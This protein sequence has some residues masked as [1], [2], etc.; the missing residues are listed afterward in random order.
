MMGRGYRLQASGFSGALLAALLFLPLVAGAQGRSGG[1]AEARQ[2]VQEANALLVK[3]KYRQAEALYKEAMRKDVQLEDA[4]NRYSMLLYV[5]RRHEEGIK[6]ARAG[7]REVPY[8]TELRALLGM[9]LSRLGRH[10]EAHGH[11]R[12]AAGSHQDRFEIQ[13]VYAQTCLRQKDYAGAIKG[14]R[15]YFKHRPKKISR[16]DSAFSVMLATALLRS[17]DLAGA[18]TTVTGVL[19]AHPHNTGAQVVMAE[20]LLRA[21]DFSAAVTA[22]E[23]LRRKTR[24][25]EVR[26]RLGQAYVGIR[27]FGPA[28]AL[29]DELLT[30]R[31]DDPDA[32]L[33][34]GDA[35]MGL[36]RHPTALV[37]Y[38]KAAGKAAGKERAAEVRLRR[39][40]ALLA[41]GRHSDVL[42][43]LPATDLR[44]D[45]VLTVRLRAA[46]G[47]GQ[48]QLA[49]EH[50]RRL[51]KQGAPSDMEHP[52][53]AGLALGAAGKH[54]EAIKL[55]A[56]T[57]DSSPRHHRAR[58]A[59]VRSLCRLAAEEVERGDTQKALALLSRARKRWP[60]SVVVNRNLGLLNLKLG[61]HEASLEA[62]DRV[63][64]RAP[65]DYV[66]SRLAGRALAAM[67]QFPLALARME[68]AI[69]VVEPRGGVGLARALDE[70]ATV[71][72]RLDQPARAVRDLQR[73]ARLLEAHGGSPL[74]TN[75]Q[76]NLILAR[77]HLARWL[78]KKGQ[79][80]KAYREVQRALRLNNKVLSDEE[81][82]AVKAAAVMVA[83]STGHVTAARRLV[84]KVKA[85]RLEKVLRAPFNRLGARLLL[86][87]T[88]Y[89]TPSPRTR[90][91]AAAQLQRL[92]LKVPQPARATLNRLALSALEQTAAR[93]YRRGRIRAARPALVAAGRARLTFSPEQRHNLAVVRYA[94]GKRRAAL[95]ELTGLQARVPM[96]TCNLAVHQ[97]NAG[98]ARGAHDLF[99]RCARSKAP[100]PNLKQILEMK[101]RFLGVP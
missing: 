73:A 83:L 57:L 47:A 101:R 13:A 17:G 30:A 26:L 21:K 7:L 90:L 50:A 45:R 37:A 22:H 56:R 24:A 19:E 71:R 18:R 95:E 54:A 89:L 29:A 16:R 43:L 12:Q 97:E 3:G 39:A 10:Q 41:L 11:L 65:Q 63:L 25:A 2:A 1:A 64:Q 28:L 94:A 69:K 14:L 46:L 60:A 44:D 58:A 66:A 51:L 76:Q 55:L 6:I 85:S 15:A 36:R 31:R 42:R 88:D 52:F 92:A 93:H 82:T 79:G 35:A 77:V 96:A 23:R 74:A 9:N 33:L 5:Q 70:A 61:R 99:S 48:V 53:H 91:R 38:S 34:R 27:R 98:N 68:V 86:A 87:Y 100:F 59:L 32:L 72:L 49:N 4:Y 8:S 81:R 40:R 67:G 75:V 62:L 84:R 80:R 78:L 20:L